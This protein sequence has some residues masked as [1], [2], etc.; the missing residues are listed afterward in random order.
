MNNPI[1]TDLLIIGGGINGSG[2]AADASGRGLSVILC[3]K[4]DL[5]QATSSA[6]SKLIHGG[7]RYLEQFNFKLVRE[8]LAEREILMNKAPHLVQAINFILPHDKHL[9]PTWMIRLGLLLYDHLAKRS[10]LP[11]SKKINLEKDQAGLPL[12]AQFKT[13]F[14]YSDCE[15]DDA[16]LVVAN[17]L[18]AREL[19]ATILTQTPCLKA[20][21]QGKQWV[22]T[23]FDKNTGENITVTAKAIVNA[24]GPWVSEV[25]HNVLKIDTKSRVT[26]VKGSHIVV[27]KLYDGQHAYLLQNPDQRVIF[28]RPYLDDFTLIGTT[29]LNYD[30][31]LDHVNITD[32]ETDY[33]CN[34]I[35]HYFSQ[36]LERSKIVWCYAGVRPLYSIADVAPSKISRGYHLEINDE[37]Q[38]APLLSVF[39]GKLTTFRHL[40][41]NALEKL[42]PYFENMSGDWTAT[43][44]LPGGDLGYPNFSEFLDAREQQYAWLPPSLIKRY[45]KQYGT[46]IHKLLINA[47]N[48][49]DMGKHFGA[50]LYEREIKYL[51]SNEWAKTCDDIIWRRTKLGLYLTADQKEVIAHYVI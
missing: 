45:A 43:S 36:T 41:E 44:K 48:L 13:G 32:E 16:R 50:G 10:Q 49:D 12:K 3:E 46:R 6:S 33:L 19:G 25:I 1:T 15:T 37:A 42:K 7:L 31:D 9:R 17:A 24:A 27:P 51:I 2:I 8:A 21:R 28:V 35:S 30:D 40:A 20:S 29:D 38:S 18:A 22:A 34:S 5:A 4:D 47:K 14:R 11:A 23:L 26:W 39:G